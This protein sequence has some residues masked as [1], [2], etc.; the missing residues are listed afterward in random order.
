MSASPTNIVPLNIP[1]IVPDEFGAWFVIK[2][3]YGWL[4]GSRRDAL[5]ALRELTHEARA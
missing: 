1:R 2:G 4:F 3:A 5:R